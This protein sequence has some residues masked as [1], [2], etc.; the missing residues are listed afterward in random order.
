MPLEPPMFLSMH[1]LCSSLIAALISQVCFAASNQ[2]FSLRRE[3][4]TTHAA[5]TTGGESALYG[6]R[7]ASFSEERSSK[8]LKAFQYTGS[9]QEFIVP[10]NITSAVIDV[11]G[12]Q[13][14]DWRLSRVGGLGGFVSS[15]VS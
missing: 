11:Y 5:L 1:F 12:A 14:G 8:I 4:E 2:Q 15:N 9:A 6:D 13:G 3:A 7:V 10:S